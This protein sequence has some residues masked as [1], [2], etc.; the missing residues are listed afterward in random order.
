MSAKIIELPVDKAIRVI[1]E[2]PRKRVFYLETT[3][4]PRDRVCLGAQSIG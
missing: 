3:T 1:S 2:I 4:I